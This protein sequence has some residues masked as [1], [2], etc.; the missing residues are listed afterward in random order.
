MKYISTNPMFSKLV[1]NIDL[2]GVNAEE[3]HDFIMSEFDSK[4][5][6]DIARTDSMIRQLG[7]VDY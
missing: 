2:F 1:L 3:C 7:I 6:G 4:I 5:E